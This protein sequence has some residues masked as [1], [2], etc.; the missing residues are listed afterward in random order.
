MTTTVVA[1][2]P[3]P[4]S[5][6]LDAA[7]RL[8]TSLSGEQPDHVIDVVELGAGLLGWG[9]PAVKNAVDTVSSSNLVIF[10]SP[11]FKATYTGILKLFLDQFA[12]GEGL[13]D[14][15]AVPL[16]LG[17]GPAHAMAPDLLLKPVLVELGATC[18]VAGLYLIDSTY[19]EDSRIADYAQ[20]WAPVLHATTR[21][22][23]S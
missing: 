9:D 6:T 1:G 4:G 13:R 15:T 8:A 10:A 17:A 11:T 20:R 2:N 23:A 5:R 14:V 21:T 22:E 19:T 7:T 3:K 16:M 12:T 18:P